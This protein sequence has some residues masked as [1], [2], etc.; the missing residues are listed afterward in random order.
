MADCRRK[1]RFRSV[2]L[3]PD[4]V[5]DSTADAWAAV[6]TPVTIHQGTLLIDELA[7][8]KGLPL[9]RKATELYREATLRLV[10]DLDPDTL[11]AVYGLAMWVRE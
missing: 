2:G 9:N 1:P 4:S 3:Y 11:P 7:Q 8:T 5:E 10:P 6:T